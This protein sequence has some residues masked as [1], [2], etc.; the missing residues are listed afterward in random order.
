MKA[1]ESRASREG[2]WSIDVVAMEGW[3][4][5]KRRRITE[6][7]GFRERPEDGEEVVVVSWN[8]VE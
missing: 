1:G 7:H 3:E 2:H 4:A 6:C 5:T 8:G